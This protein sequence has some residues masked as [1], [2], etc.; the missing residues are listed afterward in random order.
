MRIIAAL[1][2]MIHM[3][4]GAV[5]HEQKWPKGDSLLEFLERHSLPLSIYYSLDRE[6]KELAEEIYAG[7][8]FQILKGED[9][10][11]EQV[12]IPISEEMQMHIFA[13]REC[14][15]G[16][17]LKF[18][19]VIY[20]EQS[21]A[22]VL[23]IQKS[24][25]QDIMKATDNTRLAN[26]FI[27]AYQR[28][29]NFRREVQRGNKLVIMY[30][31][32]YRLGKRFGY[33]R[34][35]TA[36]IETGRREN[37]LFLFEDGRYYDKK[38]KEVEGFMF[39]APVSY[40]R[41]SSRFT[42]RRWHP[43]LKRYR[44]HLGI[45]YAAPVGRAVKAAGNGKVT[46]VGRKGGY[47]KTIT[48]K[49]DYGYKTL[50]GHLN[51]YRKGIQ[52]GKWVKKGQ[53]I[54]YVGSTGMSTGPHLHFGLYKNGR[55]RNPAK[56]VRVT[57]RALSGEKQKRFAMFRDESIQKIKDIIIAHSQ[58]REGMNSDYLVQ[59]NSDMKN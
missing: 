47:G 50:Y 6:E 36:M 17:C 2:I 13:S 18:I 22:L 29:I 26:E 51:G 52:R 54:G 34:I 10:A 58:P 21:E 43:I 45:D 37:Y 8:K 46:Y 31:Q 15:E 24:P 19:P 25:Y 20:D 56:A 28:S 35:T 3:T 16:Y 5:L 38:G 4:F 57:K 23:D 30:D 59:L 40:T 14:E 39:R 32:K 48:I 7:V 11:I 12:L 33:P 55:A 49:H 27:Q 53:V 1:S 9:E 42:K 44:P 41:I